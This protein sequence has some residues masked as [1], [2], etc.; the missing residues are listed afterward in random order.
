MQLELS[1]I[2]SASE[3]TPSFEYSVAISLPRC[4]GVRILV[5]YKKD[6]FI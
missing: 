2:K 5:L 4:I 6:G 1:Q 3:I